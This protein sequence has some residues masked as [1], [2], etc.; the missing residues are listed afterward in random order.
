MDA[1]RRITDPPAH[2]FFGYYE[3]SPWNASE[4]YLLAH[5]SKFQDRRPTAEDTAGVC[6]IDDATGAVE[7]VAQ[8]GAWDFQQG[9][10]LQWLGPDYERRFVFND[11]GDDGFVARIHDVEAG[12]V[13]T[14]DHPIYAVAP[15]GETAF[16]LDYDRLDETRPGYGY[17]PIQSNGDPSDAT[18]DSGSDDGTG[19]HPHPDDEGVYRVDLSTGEATLLVSL[20]ELAAFDPVP[21]M[22][23]GVHWVNHVQLSPGG[24]RVGF[25]HRSE[26][27]DDRRWLDRLF[28][29][30]A[31]GS[32]LDCLHSGF[33][34]HY[35]WRTDSD[36]L[37]WT[38][39]DGEAFYRYD[40]DGSVAPVARGRLP[41]DGHC[42]FSPDG[43]W[44]LLDSYPDD[45]RQRG[46]YLY[47]WE[48]DELV[49][50]GSVHSPPVEES[51]LRC[52]L[53]PR[54]D[55]SGERVCFDSTHEGSRQ[56][57][58]CDVSDVTSSG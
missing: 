19:L 45:D 18:G 43:E 22:D 37:A 34:S 52:D 21:S 2:H 1:V 29:V 51:S 48:R 33:V 3:K 26:T 7:Q 6:L 40:L 28:V 44:L 57:Y 13:D 55:R 31:D 32:G 38:D 39:R 54:W 47:H 56:M 16:T 30:D 5:E 27:P 24:E 35:D 12:L 10:M 8:T 41:R 23:H 14:V 36:L 58:V 46:L 42:S 53:H 11:R 15:D 17:A 4:T 50:L 9:A 25:I 49:E 20:A